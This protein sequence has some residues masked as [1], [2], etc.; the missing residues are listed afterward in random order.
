[1]LDWW[2]EGNTCLGERLYGFVIE[3]LL[4]IG[5]ADDAASCGQRL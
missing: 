4:L 1:M 3:C 5:D 2:C